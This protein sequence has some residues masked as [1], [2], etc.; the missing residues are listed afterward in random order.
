MVG[1][2]YGIGGIHRF[3]GRRVGG[4]R[5]Y[6]GGGGRSGRGSHFGRLIFAASGQRTDQGQTTDQSD[7]IAL[8]IIAS[9]IIQKIGFHPCLIMCVRRVLTPGKIF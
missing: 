2:G 4:F 7:L 5:G 3:R 1:G 8:H 6:G 9:C